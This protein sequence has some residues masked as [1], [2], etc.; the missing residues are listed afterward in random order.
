MIRNSLAKIKT[1]LGRNNIYQDNIAVIFPQDETFDMEGRLE[2]L[3]NLVNWILRPA[4]V[5]SDIDACKLSTLRMQHLLSILDRDPVK[6]AQFAK[7]IRQTLVDV[8]NPKFFSEVGTAWG[9]GFL[10][11]LYE[12]FLRK[13]LPSSSMEKDLTAFFLAA[14]PDTENILRF[15]EMDESVFH[16]FIDMLTTGEGSREFLASLF[17]EVENTLS[18]LSVHCRAIGL[19]PDILNRTKHLNFRQSPF[20]T[21]DFRPSELESKN[22]DFS[23]VDLYQKFLDLKKTIRDCRRDISA[24]KAGQEG[25][26]ISINVTYNLERLITYLNRMEMLIDFVLAKKTE[27]K[28]VTSR[29]LKVI[30]SDIDHRFSFM[31]LVQKNIAKL[32]RMSLEHS[33]Q[34]GDHYINRS[35]QEYLIML[36]ASLGGGALTAATVFL[37]YIIYSIHAAG[38]IQGFLLSLNYVVSFVAIYLLGFTLGTKQPAHTAAALVKKLSPNMNDLSMGELVVEASHLIRSQVVS[39]FGNM[40][41]VVATVLLF[42]ELF[43]FT[44]GIHMMNR[45]SAIHTAQSVDIWGSCLF[46]AAFTGVLLWASS[47]IGGWAEN[48]F[49][50]RGLWSRIAHNRKIIRV[51]G[52]SKT[53]RAAEFLKEKFAGITTNVALGIFL[54]FLPELFKFFGF[55]LEVRH[56]TLSSGSLAAAFVTLGM[57]GQA[58]VVVWRCIVGIIG[59][60]LLNVGVSFTLSFWLAARAAGIEAEVQRRIYKA[61]IYRF[62]THPFSFLLP[63]WP[64]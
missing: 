34:T 22:P 48:W 15:S 63:R 23:D 24:I 13:F 59:V 54:G 55:P 20:Y 28:M 12:I 42:T 17:L 5:Y 62:A 53:N 11:E 1:A 41:A 57:H 50:L 2:W 25:T 21:L 58:G 4:P 26:G 47:L 6:K 64:K 14:F 16:P 51:F 40:V 36:R 18:L 46:F 31:W 27:L 45:E 35:R 60:G 61:V 10:Q 19:T 9:A 33:A 43:Q 7:L 30:W 8:I 49:L 3:A 38:F 29:F 56:V 32:A 39:I 44:F 37:K 52:Y